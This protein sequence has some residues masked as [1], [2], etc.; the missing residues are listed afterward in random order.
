[1]KFY[2]FT[3]LLLATFSG[4]AQNDSTGTIVAGSSLSSSPFMIVGSG[5]YDRFKSTDWVYRNG[6]FIA[7]E[8]FSAVKEGGMPLVTLTR[9]EIDSLE[10]YH[11][12]NNGLS[13]ERFERIAELMCD[14][15]YTAYVMGWKLWPGQVRKTFKMGIWQNASCS[16]ALPNIDNDEQMKSRLLRAILDSRN[17]NAKRSPTPKWPCPDEVA[18]APVAVKRDTTIL[19]SGSG[20]KLNIKQEF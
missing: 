8:N 9:F 11:L 4:N 3:A 6:R 10:S 20:Q 16:G 15:T 12:Y 1:M 17:P 7:S 2:L 14:S 18:P 19:F 5:T 13:D